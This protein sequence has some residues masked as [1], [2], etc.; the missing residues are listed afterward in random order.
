MAVAASR[1]I[2]A[3]WPIYWHPLALVLFCVSPICVAEQVLAR[4]TLNAEPQSLLLSSLLFLP[5]KT[6][7]RTLG[8][9]RP[10]HLSCPMAIAIQLT[11]VDVCRWHEHRKL[12]GNLWPLGNDFGK[13]GD[14]GPQQRSATPR[15]GAVARQSPPLSAGLMTSETGGSTSL[16]R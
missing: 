7:I 11:N 12:H 2:E 10:C 13:H 15:R 6:H 3:R 8:L 9:S 4:Q 5:V 16:S 1:Y 14:A